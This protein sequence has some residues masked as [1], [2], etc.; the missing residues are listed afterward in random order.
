[1]VMERFDERGWTVTLFSLQPT[2]PD[3]CL[4]FQLVQ[5]DGYR[6]DALPAPVP[7]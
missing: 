7:M 1:M 4:N 6:A 2:F 3:E 5:F